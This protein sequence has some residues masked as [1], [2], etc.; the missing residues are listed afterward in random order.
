VDCVPLV[1]L[2]PVQPPDPVHDVALLE[3]QVTVDAPLLAMLLG[4]TL[5]ETVGA[6]GAEEETE[7]VTDCA[8]EPPAP[9]QV[10]VNFCVALSAALFCAPL[11]AS[12]PLQPPEAVQEVASLEVQFN[13]DVPPLATVLG[14]A[15]SDTIGAEGVTGP[16]GVEFAGADELP[17]PLQA[18][19]ATNPASVTHALTRRVAHD[20]AP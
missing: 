12:E 6:E 13:V 15:L 10:S 9:V 19:S 18:A 7:T 3:D 16:S 17:P 1:A 2:L 4:F 20:P 8:A 14:L 11:V 5:I